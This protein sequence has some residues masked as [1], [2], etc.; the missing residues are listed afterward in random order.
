MDPVGERLNILISRI[1]GQS[2]PDDKAKYSELS[3]MN[4]SDGETSSLDIRKWC[5]EFQHGTLI[6]GG[7]PKYTKFLGAVNETF[8]RVGLVI[9]NTALAH[10]GLA[11][12]RQE[13][14]PARIQI[15][16]QTLLR[17][18]GFGSEEEAL[19]YLSTPF[20]Q[21]V[22]PDDFVALRTEKSRRYESLLQIL[23]SPAEL[24][25]AIDAY[26]TGRMKLEV[27]LKQLTTLRA[28]QFLGMSGSP[29]PD[30]RWKNHARRLP[31]RPDIGVL[32]SKR[33]AIT[34]EL[35]ALKADD[36]G[37][38]TKE[39]EIERR[40]DALRP[41]MDLFVKKESEYWA[42]LVEAVMHVRAIE[43]AYATEANLIINGQ[44]AE[45]DRVIGETLGYIESIKPAMT[46]VPILMA[47][48]IRN[49]G[50][51]TEEKIGRSLDA[52]FNRITMR[53]DFNPVQTILPLLTGSSG[54]THLKSIGFEKALAE[55]IGSMKKRSQVVAAL[56][57]M[58]FDLM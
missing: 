56:G 52:T 27:L 25:G 12:M 29:D 47:E 35:E 23:P 54:A 45:V 3:A 15:A 38:A 24:D 46:I 2:H 1:A 9:M 41:E 21:N 20:K 42:A 26:Q 6:G 10:E 30:T 13:K 28:P 49:K 55:G 18:I 16:A 34:A 8:D 4:L 43:E 17:S 5:P 22:I 51:P 57:V 58:L 44:R 7:T 39:A 36:A 48:I 33:I 32:Q 11:A 50:S 14:D 19:R 53:Q 31:R 37:R 40:L